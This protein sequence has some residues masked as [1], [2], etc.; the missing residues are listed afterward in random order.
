ME[1]GVY[2][3]NIFQFKECSNVDSVL[4]KIEEW[5][6]APEFTVLLQSF[7][8]TEIQGNSLKNQIS[9]LVEFSSIWDF[10]GKQR[11]N[12]SGNTENARWT[13]EDCGFSGQQQENI[14][15]AANKLGLI[16]CTKPSKKEYDYIIVLGGARMSC[17]FRMKHAKQIC[18]L[19]GVKTDSIVGLA[20]MREVMDS[21][22]N[23][24]DTYARE[25]K[26]EFDLMRAALSH[27]FGEIVL[28][29]KEK[30]MNQN[31]NSSW[32]KEVYQI[33]D[34]RLILLAA[35][36]GEPQKRRA[37]TADTFAFFME[38]MHVENKRDILLV[39]S[40]IYVPYQQLEAIRMLGLPYGHLVETI[41]FPNE[42]SAGLQGLQRPENYLQEIRSV[43]QSMG[44]FLEYVQ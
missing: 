5:I 34:M 28:D 27:V 33:Q 6:F 32:A 35:P 14:T 31:L 16:G 29:E 21:E 30:C 7:G 24:T 9:D 8:K 10:R 42:W 39:T 43:L 4:K 37:N 11:K 19:Y 18:D 41:G 1:E 36:S 3:E 2:M 12:V 13:I 15:E 17:L 25:A 40:Q 20:G 44:R 26:T 22:R 23:A 38:R